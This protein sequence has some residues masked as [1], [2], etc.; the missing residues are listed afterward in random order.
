MTMY[1]APRRIERKLLVLQRM[2]TKYQKR[3]REDRSESCCNDMEDQVEVKS[4]S[5]CRQYFRS[6]QLLF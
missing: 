6:K 2:K 5:S 1:E 4:M 3:K